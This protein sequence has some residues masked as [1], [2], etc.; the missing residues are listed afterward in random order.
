VK[1]LPA[2][3]KAYVRGGQLKGNGAEKR[4]ASHHNE[5]GTPG[6]KRK[7]KERDEWRSKDA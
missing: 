4:D 7:E 3:S 5:D 1:S 2:V 6:E